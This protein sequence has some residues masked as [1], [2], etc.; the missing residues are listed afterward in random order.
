MLGNGAR[1]RPRR[2]ATG[3]VIERVEEGIELQPVPKG[4]EF[5]T[6]RRWQ[7]GPVLG[8]EQPINVALQGASCQVALYLDDGETNTQEVTRR[9]HADWKW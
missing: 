8:L 3:L 1:Q 7:A 2:T 9:A 6:L 4:Y 5:F